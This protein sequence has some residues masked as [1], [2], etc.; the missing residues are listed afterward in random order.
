MKLVGKPGALVNYEKEESNI[1]EDMTWTW[2]CMQYKLQAWFLG[3]LSHCLLIFVSLSGEKP[4][5][6][7]DIC[8]PHLQLLPGCSSQLFRLPGPDPGLL[9]STSREPS[10]CGPSSCCP[11]PGSPGGSVGAGLSGAVHTVRRLRQMTWRWTWCWIMLSQTLTISWNKMTLDSMFSTLSYFFPGRM[12]NPLSFGL[13]LSVL[14]HWGLRICK[15]LCSISCCSLVGTNLL[16]LSGT[17]WKATDRP[18]CST[19]TPH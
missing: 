4:G 5:S 11:G 3:N 1:I 15:C 10:H 13:L 2:T 17:L 19:T 9:P 14:C 12:E 16:G 18:F 7:G 6:G 8:E